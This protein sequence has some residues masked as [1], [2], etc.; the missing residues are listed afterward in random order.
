MIT[1]RSN[2]FFLGPPGT[3][4]TYECLEQVK[5]EITEKDTKPINIAYLSF[6]RIAAGEAFKRINDDFENRY[7]E[8]EFDN[9]RTLHSMCLRNLPD[10]KDSVMGESDYKEFG[11]I[12]PVNW[13]TK[14][15]SWKVKIDYSKGKLTTDNLYL[16][17][18]QLANN[19]MISL[20]EQYDNLKAEEKAHI[21]INTLFS[22]EEQLKKFKKDR[23]LHDFDDMLLEFSKLPDNR[24]PSFDLLIVDEAQDCS[25]LQWKCIRKLEDRAKRTIVAGDDDQAI[26]VWAGSDVATFR[27]FY[28]NPKFE[29]IQL[30]ESQRVPALIHSL[31]EKIIKKDTARL[32]K[33]YEPKKEC[34]AIFKRS[35]IKQ[36]K[37]I[38]KQSVANDH[39]LLILCCIHEHLRAAEQVLKDLKI[40]Y[41]YEDE[42]S[43]KTSLIKAIKLWNKWKE[44]EKLKGEQIKTLYGY[45]ETGTGVEWGF[46]KGKKAP[47]DLEEYTL[48]DCMKSYGLLVDG[49]WYEVFRKKVKE[50]DLIYFKGLEDA[51]KA[52]DS[53]PLVRLSTINSIKGSE[54]YNVILYSDISGHEKTEQE[55]NELH[56]K[57]YVGVTRAIQNLVI[58]H[59]RIKSKS[60]PLITLAN[61]EIELTE[62]RR[63]NEKNSIQHTSGG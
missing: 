28:D 44:G 17:Q 2:I 61:R 21:R 3:G 25:K 9:F 53:P 62:W 49:K 41:Y 30:Q 50:S 51:G 42:G 14:N 19:R 38:I 16:K 4:K 33:L 60:Y 57:M 18:I 54:A 48:Q 34:G 39:R 23:G 45:L 6:T 12:V 52:Y 13:Q 43:S 35:D 15:L 58:L 5:R 20:Q 47:Q 11:K 63:R 40:K 27:S 22:L 10:L 32:P 46:K 56:R 37:G 1:L 31:A 29:N 7:E 36:C 59:P 8:K 55:K 24:I 26:F